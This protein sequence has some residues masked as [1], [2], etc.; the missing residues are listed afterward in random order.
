MTNQ[1]IEQM[2]SHDPFILFVKDDD[3]DCYMMRSILENIG[4]TDLNVVNL[5]GF[6]DAVGL[7]RQQLIQHSGMDEFPYLYLNGQSLGTTDEIIQSVRAGVLQEKLKNAGLAVLSKFETPSLD[8]N[9]FGYPKGGLTLPDN[10]KKN[11]LLGCCGS[12]AADKIPQLIKKLLDAGHDVKLVPSDHGE[13]FF[14][15]FGMEEIYS[16]LKPTDIYRDL[17][18]WNF[19]YIEFGMKLRACHLALCDWADCLVVAPITCNSMAKVA[20]GIGDNLFSSILVAWQYQVKPVVFCPACNTHMWNNITT[21]RNVEH[22]KL[23]GANFVGPNKGIL[24]NG[25]T[26]VGMM[27]TIDEIT[28][29]VLDILVDLE[30]PDRVAMRWGAQAAAS[31]NPESWLRIYRK[32]DET[33]E[34][35]NNIVDINVTDSEVGDNLLHYAAGGEG[36]L[37]GNGH[38]KGSPDLAAANELI[39]RGIDVNKMNKYGFTPLHVAVMNESL[40]MVK[41]LLDAGADP[42]LLTEQG[43]SCLDLASSIPPKPRIVATLLRHLAGS[44]FGIDR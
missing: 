30:H 23:L 2:I 26:G 18:E 10:D 37:S 42:R 27:A 29:K 41:L 31:D 33:D 25:T 13:H 24:S 9:L 40:E 12:S 28:E 7:L 15:D 1:T 3:P 39:K 17:D 36:S 4:A 8:K 11:I 32:M 35:G 16:L 6:S 19:R 5:T 38:E 14:K 34:H 43:Q 22:L 44:R 20:N 21:Q